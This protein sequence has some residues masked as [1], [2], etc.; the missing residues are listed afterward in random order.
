MASNV[1]SPTGL[2]QC[3]AAAGF[4]GMEVVRAAH[5][6]PLKPFIYDS[7]APLKSLNGLLA[8]PDASRPASGPWNVHVG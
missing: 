7:P 6:L 4:Q 8:I 2:V 3:A 1:P 5:P